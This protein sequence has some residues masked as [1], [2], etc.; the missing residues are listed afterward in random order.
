MNAL[1]LIAQIE[2]N[3]FKNKFTHLE[4]VAYYHLPVIESLSSSIVNNLLQK[5]S[6]EKHHLTVLSTVKLIG[7]GEEDSSNKEFKKYNGQMSF[8]RINYRWPSSDIPQEA[9]AVMTFI[10]LMAKCQYL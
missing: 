1:F 7:W 2:G 5:K 6:N 3:D 8:E 10:F 9:S 4:C